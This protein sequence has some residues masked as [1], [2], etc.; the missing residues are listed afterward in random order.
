MIRFHGEIDQVICVTN[1]RSLSG[2]RIDQSLSVS[3]KSESLFPHS[4]VAQPRKYQSWFWVEDLDQG[5]LL[6]RQTPGLKL[7]TLPGGKVKRGE[8]LVKALK[9]EV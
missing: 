3:W 4:A 2:F 7:W 5:V 1:I 8:S 6:V 9:R